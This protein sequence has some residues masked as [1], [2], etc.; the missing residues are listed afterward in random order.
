MKA[1]QDRQLVNPGCQ[2]SLNVQAV[3]VVATPALLLDE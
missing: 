2:L 1:E 3:I